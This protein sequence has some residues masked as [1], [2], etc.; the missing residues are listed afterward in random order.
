MTLNVRPAQP[1]DV[2]ELDLRE[3]DR[4]EVSEGWRTRLVEAIRENT[5]VAYRDRQGRLV[6]LFGVTESEQALSP[7]LLCSPLVA[8]HRRTVV[9]HA[10]YYV[11]WLRNA[12]ANRLVFNW[13]PPH[14]HANRAFVLALGFV[15]VPSPRPGWDLFY[16]PH[17]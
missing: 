12:A 17:V 6:G 10:R 4:A 1:R 8:K 11:S 15:I 5:A 9:R 3:E 13:I 14:A 16:L 7:W 2:F